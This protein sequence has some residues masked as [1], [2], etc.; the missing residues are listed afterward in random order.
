[1]FDGNPGADTATA[2][3]LIDPELA[4]NTGGLSVATPPATVLIAPSS[5]LLIALAASTSPSSVVSAASGK[6]I[7]SIALFRSLFSS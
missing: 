4:E 1:V 2:A 7:A 5:A 6:A 3:P